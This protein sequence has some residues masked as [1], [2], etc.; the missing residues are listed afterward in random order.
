[1]E[2]LLRY[3]FQK[4]DAKTHCCLVILLL[5]SLLVGGCGQDPSSD[6]SAGG[7]SGVQEMPNLKDGDFWDGFETEFQN[8]FRL[9]EEE[10]LI[11]NEGGTTF[12]GEV[13]RRFSN[14]SISRKSNYQGGLLHGESFAWFETGSMKSRAN[15]KA[16]LK[17]G[18]EV[19]WTEEGKE[20]SRKFYIDGIED[21]SRGNEEGE[22]TPFGQSAEA[23][24]L[25]KW[26]G[27][28]RQFGEKFAGDPGRGGT[29]YIRKTEELYSGTITA[30]DDAGRKEAELN[31]KDG[32]WHGSITKWDLNG[33]ILEKAQFEDGKLMR[34]EIKG[35]KAF[36]PN[37]I[38][39]DSPFGRQ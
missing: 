25:A 24:A 36:D 1:M 10:K 15:F 18:L 11:K 12:S 22:D 2:N 4:M 27:N 7:A 14:G 37:Q 20:Y 21:L 9:D 23:L 19:I 8:D 5:L 29:V 6:S 33:G 30:L 34:F 13:I 35:G 16:G 17:E 3:F 39:N 28:G 31:F 26:E 38:I 32:L